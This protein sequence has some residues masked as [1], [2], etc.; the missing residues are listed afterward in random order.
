M[1]VLC[2]S[3]LRAILNANADIWVRC[4]NPRRFDTSG[5]IQGNFNNANGGIERLARKHLFEVESEHIGS[6]H[7]WLECCMCHFM[8]EAF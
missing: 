4:T 6:I 2:A 7:H 3:D 8:D 5:C 1:L